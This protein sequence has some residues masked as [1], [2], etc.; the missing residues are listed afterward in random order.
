MHQGS[1]PEPFLVAMVMNR[2]T[3]GGGQ[4]RPL[5]DG[6]RCG[7]STEKVREQVEAW[8][9]VTERMRGEPRGSVTVQPVQ[10]WT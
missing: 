5:T 9:G 1:D 10:M 4:E 2:L 3:D 8:R 6:W 7:E